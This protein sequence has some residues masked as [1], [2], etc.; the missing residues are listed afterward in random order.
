VESFKGILKNFAY[1]PLHLA[2][3]FGNSVKKNPHLKI[4][5]RGSAGKLIKG[6]KATCLLLLAIHSSPL[7][8]FRD[9]CEKKSVFTLPLYCENHSRKLSHLV[10]VREQIDCSTRQSFCPRAIMGPRIVPLQ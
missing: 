5:S 6:N 8:A 1:I 4:H 3:K 7:Y 9:A 2:G 10:S